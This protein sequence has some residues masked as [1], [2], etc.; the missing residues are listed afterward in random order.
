MQDAFGVLVDEHRIIAKVLRAIETAA[1]LDVPLSFYERAVAFGVH[2]I[3]GCHHA[4]EER[5]LYPYLK[6]RGMPREYGPLGVA[7]EEHDASR[8]YLQSMQALVAAGDVSGLRPVSLSYV[9][10]MREH[11]TIEDEVLF[12]LGRAMLTSAEIGVIC[13]SHAEVAQPQPS[14][15][16]Y[17]QEGDRLLAE[18]GAWA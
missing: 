11:M 1:A 7:F 5:K 8:A 12:P 15:E 2:F 13:A 9:A 10:S 14:Y 16:F 3:D 18:V 17:V 4:K 6:Q